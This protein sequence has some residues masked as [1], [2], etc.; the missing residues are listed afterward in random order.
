M[1]VGLSKNN[2]V[3]G[4]ISVLIL[5]AIV[6]Y[7]ISSTVIETGPE[8]PQGEQGEIGPQGQTGS[9]GSRGPQGEKGDRGLIGPVGPAGPK[10]DKGNTGLTGAQGIQGPRG[11]TGAKGDKGEPGG[12][13]ADITALLHSEFYNVWG[14]TDY[15][16]VEGLMINFGTDYA[17]SVTIVITWGIYGG[18]TYI[19]PAVTIG[20]LNGHQIYEFSHTFYFEGGYDYLTYEITWS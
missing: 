20:G 12:V 19:G 18:G 8:G 16:I 2:L 17:Y 11:Y 15:H 9:T 14:G 10:G 7:G 6:N 3:V 4:L 13:E 5:S 1:T